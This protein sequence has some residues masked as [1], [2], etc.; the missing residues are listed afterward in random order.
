MP[1]QIKNGI[2][3][4]SNAVS[5]TQAQYDA[6][7]TAEKNNGTVYYIYDV[8]DIYSGNVV[9]NVVLS[10]SKWA[11]NAY[12][13]T[14]HDITGA[15]I[16]FLT[17]PSSISDEMYSAIQSANIR[18]TNQTNGSITLQA[19]GGAPSINLTITLIIQGI[20]MGLQTAE[21]VTYDNSTSGL[22]AVNVQEAVDELSNGLIA[23]ETTF[24]V[25]LE[26]GAG[27]TNSQNAQFTSYTLTEKGLYLLSAETSGM[28]ING[29]TYAYFTGNNVIPNL[30]LYPATANTEYYHE[31]I[32]QFVK[33]GNTPITVSL[34]YWDSNSIPEHKYKIYKILG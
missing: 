15:N 5:L 19:L 23:F 31:Q 27:R 8:D 6:L 14:D 24:E 29:R 18:V 4:G 2:I 3:Y 9:K 25:T 17:Y 32:V 7:S 16:V 10:A 1:Y 34:R 28:N 12:T 11:S 13:I 30:S 33:V 20:D 21:Y 26:S 22:E